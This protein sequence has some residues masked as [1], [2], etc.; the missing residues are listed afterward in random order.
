MQKQ[1]SN[2]L[3]RSYFEHLIITIFCASAVILG[4]ISSHYRNWQCITIAI[5]LACSVYVFFKKKSLALFIIAL[6]TIGFIRLQQITYWHTKTIEQIQKKATIVGTINSI[7]KAQHKQYRYA[8][9]ATISHY[10]KD[11][12]LHP[13]A[14]PW[15]LQCYSKQ[16]PK[17]LVCDA[18]RIDNVSLNAKSKESFSLFLIKEG[19][20][21]TAFLPFNS[22]HIIDHPAFSFTRLTHQTRTQILEGIKRKCSSS[23]MTL[24][25]AIFFG[26]RLYVKKQYTELKDLFCNWG[27]V[28][29]L[30][31]SGLHMVIF[32]LFLQLVLQWI[33]MPFLIKQLMMIC[34]SLVYT[35]LSW[36]SIS[37]ARAFSSFLWYKTSQMCGLQTDVVHIITVLTCI[38]L[39]CN[40]M[41][42]FFL[43]FQLSF[44]L[45]WILAI[46]N[47]YLSRQNRDL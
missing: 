1:Q 28:H 26:N 8:I 35:T 29:F 18:V 23:T 33:P 19:I 36:Q 16:S 45:T 43:D 10:Y 17:A 41:L 3:K 22:I 13:Y 40:P 24:I 7:E 21:A 31:R 38:F 44:G 2:R 34:V 42:I 6:F 5:V 9:S 20:H 30:A 47:H 25:A 14:I 4:I 37:F 11:E 15:T 27:I 32:I 12:Q 46:T 39:I